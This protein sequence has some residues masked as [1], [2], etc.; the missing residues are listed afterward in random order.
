M[1]GDVDKA[2]VSKFGFGEGNILG[3][4]QERLSTDEQL[5][6]NIDIIVTTSEE[7]KLFMQHTLKHIQ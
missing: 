5:E 1:M 2:K 3:W 7:P 6:K 4:F